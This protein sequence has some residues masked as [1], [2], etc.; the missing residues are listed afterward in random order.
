MFI[1]LITYLCVPFRPF[2]GHSSPYLCFFPIILFSFLFNVFGLISWIEIICKDHILGQNWYLCYK[3]AIK[4]P[5][6]L[7]SVAIIGDFKVTPKYPLW[8]LLTCAKGY[9][10]NQQGVH[11]LEMAR[12]A[13]KMAQKGQKMAQN[14]QFSKI[15]ICVW[16]GYSKLVPGDVWQDEKW[17][18]TIQLYWTEKTPKMW[19]KLTIFVVFLTL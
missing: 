2:L 19:S 6:I 13:S 18:R 15:L 11:W 1:W 10:I 7:Y 5:S 14:G 9:K 12:T 8:V 3:L 16:C 4:W 17:I